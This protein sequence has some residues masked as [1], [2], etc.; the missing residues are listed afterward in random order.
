MASL[1]IYD[2]SNSQ[3]SSDEYSHDEDDDGL[4]DMAVSKQQTPPAKSANKLDETSPTKTDSTAS[5][6]PRKLSEDLDAIAVATKPPASREHTQRQI[7]QMQRDNRANL[8][9]KRR[10]IKWYVKFMGYINI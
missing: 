1:E 6:T 9:F 8:Y 5:T 4:M 10:S 2:S 3:L 7:K